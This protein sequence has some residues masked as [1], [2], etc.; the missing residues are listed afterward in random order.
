[1]GSARGRPHTRAGE[2]AKDDGY[3]GEFGP[4]RCV[5]RRPLCVRDGMKM[6]C[7]ARPGPGRGS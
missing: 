2:V 7:E 3:R 6:D 1:M 5:L 4:G